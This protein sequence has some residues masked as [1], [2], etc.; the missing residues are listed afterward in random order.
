MLNPLEGNPNDDQLPCFQSD[1]LDVSDWSDGFTPTG[2]GTIL[3]LCQ[4]FG[5]LIDCL[6][7]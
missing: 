3:K 1:S 6:K 5:C 2:L 4:L 7:N